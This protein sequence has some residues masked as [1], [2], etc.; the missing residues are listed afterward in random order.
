MPR[1]DCSH[2]TTLDWHNFLKRWSA[3]LLQDLDV[4]AKLPADVIASGWLGYPGAT[5]EQIE[6]AEARLGARFP[7]SYRAFLK[8]SNGWRQL[9][10]YIDHL[11]P[12]ENL[13][14]FAVA[15]QDTVDIWMETL[16]G[17]VPDDVYFAYSPTLESAMLRPEYLQTALQVSDWSDDNAV[18]LLNP[19]VISADGEWEALFLAGWLPGANRYRSFYD[20][21]QGECQAFLEY[22]QRRP[23]HEVGGVSAD[24]PR[25]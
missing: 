10:Y 13:A 21:V 9:T 20:L 4:K 24:G 18:C 22:Q 3:E 1:P 6:G 11:W 12:V 15:N 17:T 19:Q 8:V 23:P 5:E 14:W 25:D 7:P 2:M 16:T